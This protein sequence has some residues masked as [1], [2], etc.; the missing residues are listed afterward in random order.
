[1]NYKKF[2]EE[3]L[4]KVLN[5]RAVIHSSRGESA[6]GVCCW[7]EARAIEIVHA[8]GGDFSVLL[9]TAKENGYELIEMAQY[10]YDNGMEEWGHKLACMVGLFR[11][12]SLDG[13]MS[14]RVKSQ[15]NKESAK[16]PRTPEECVELWKPVVESAVCRFSSD[17]Q[18]WTYEEVFA[19][20][21]E[22]LGRLELDRDLSYKRFRA[23]A[24]EVCERYEIEAPKQGC[25]EKKKKSDEKIIELA[26]KE[27]ALGPQR[28]T[29]ELN[30]RMISVTLND[31]NRVLRKRGLNNKGLRFLA[32]KNIRL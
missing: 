20:V 4:A 27:P 30:A 21:N 7:Q 18:K 11:A 32:A 16:K 5:K 17:G 26:L 10:F 2:R 24:G 12:M 6:H 25:P 28:L 9:D 13:P 3:Q 8:A 1:M 31:V 22:V 15:K 19:D 29:N 23:L 14:E